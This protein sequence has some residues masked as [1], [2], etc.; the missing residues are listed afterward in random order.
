MPTIVLSST[1]AA[2]DETCA[3][4]KLAAQLQ[5]EIAAA[6]AIRRHEFVSD[7]GH[8]IQRD[9]PLAVINAARER[10]RRNN[11][12]NTRRIGCHAN[13]SFEI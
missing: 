6:F 9:Q 3:Y 2:M 8:Y 12:P 10:T 7:S 11:L 13:C 4:R 1:R 5:N